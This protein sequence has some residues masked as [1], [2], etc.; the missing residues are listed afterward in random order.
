[1]ADSLR[2]MMMKLFFCL[3]LCAVIC[4]AGFLT[5]CRLI[6]YH[7][8]EPV[9]QPAKET[10]SI[11]NHT[12]EV[13]GG[14]L[15]YTAIA[16]YMPIYDSSRRLKAN[17][18]FVAYFKDQP[19]QRIPRPITF[20]FNGGPGSSSV[21]LHL[22]CLGPKR[23]L[24]K[25]PGH[26]GPSGLVDNEYTWLDMTDLVFIDPIG[27]GFSYAVDPND[28][29]TFFEIHKD[30]D[31]VGYFIQSF[32][33]KYRKWLSPK[34]LV[35]ESYGTLR[36]VGLL[37]QLQKKYS[38]RI[39]DVI[40]ISS[41]LNFETISFTKE[42]DLPY[43]LYLPSYTAAAW[44]HK[45]LSGQLQADL[46]KTLAEAQ[47]WAATEYLV[48]LAKGDN[49]SRDEKTLLCDKLAAYTGLSPTFIKNHN[50]RIEVSRFTKKLLKKQHLQIG[51]IDSR[52]TGIAP[53]PFSEFID[54]DPSLMAVESSFVAA[55]N[56]YVAAD[57][58][59]SSSIPYEALS[60]KAAKSWNW[61]S[62]SGGF[63]NFTETLA[64]A[65]TANKNLRVFAAM[66]YYDLATPF[67]TQEYT[68]DHLGLD[69]RI[70]SNIHRSYYF[71]GHQIYTSMKSLKKF[72]KDITF[73][74]GRNVHPDYDQTE[75]LQISKGEDYE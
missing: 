25:K 33:T 26:I 14:I 1:M 44:Y 58:N 46:T 54:I 49:L 53:W 15:K 67:A 74:F 62:A 38:I 43:A 9:L 22:G 16:G 69:P 70:R 40:L 41:A 28:T 51:L 24:L 7:N 21:W 48:M 73:F 10:A 61:G 23:V 20:A 4:G 56:N 27:T 64:G 17:M 31:S 71:S 39:D 11:T 66:G 47:K 36:A 65:M 68:F 12:I 75:Q 55:F 63:V 29:K 45:Q 19:D 42:N 50:F 60:M 30:I 8:F 32:L 6:S 72:K 5:G 57:L 37:Q 34:Y 18:F 13:N 2:H 52:A 35:G 3:P 59:F